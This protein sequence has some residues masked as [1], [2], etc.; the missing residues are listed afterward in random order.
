M[1]FAVTQE[2]ALLLSLA[3]S[4]GCHLELLLR[5]PGKP[6]DKEYDIKKIKQLLEDQKQRRRAEDD[7]RTAAPIPRNRTA[8]TPHRGPATKRRSRRR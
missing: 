8:R 4:R 5:H 2:Q 7:R 1:S 6:L 3:K